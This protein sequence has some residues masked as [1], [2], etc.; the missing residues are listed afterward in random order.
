MS[1]QISLSKMVHNEKNVASLFDFRKMN[2]TVNNYYYQSKPFRGKI[3]VVSNMSAYA[4]VEGM[5]SLFP[6]SNP[7]LRELL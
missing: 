3:F 4:G 7:H 2:M 5:T 1:L 6:S